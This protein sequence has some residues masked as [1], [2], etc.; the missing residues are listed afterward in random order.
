MGGG[1]AEYVTTQQKISRGTDWSGMRYT[2]DELEL[3][4][5]YNNY[6]KQVMATKIAISSNVL[7]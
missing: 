2:A 3:E 1:Y 6:I 5:N 7:F 4:S